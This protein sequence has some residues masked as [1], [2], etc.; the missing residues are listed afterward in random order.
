MSVLAA[1][2]F[3]RF[4]S[5]TYLV[6]LA[7]LPLIV[8]LSLRSLSGL[9]PVRRWLA[10][11]LR[12]LV[13]TTMVFALA[14]AQR[15]Q[16]TD[17]LS[18]I[19][20][21]DRS[22]S[23]PRDQQ[24]SAFQFVTSSKEGLRATKDR[25][26]VV[27]FDGD[28]AVE[29]LPMGGLGITKIGDPVRPENTNIEEALAMAMALFTD[30]TA[31]RVVLLSDGNENV[32]HAL[33]QAD[34]Y[35]AAGVPIDVLPIRYEHGDE[36]VFER[37]SAPPTATSEETVDLQMV[38]RATKET[39]GRVTLFHNDK[40]E[41]SQPV[42]LDAGANRLKMSVPMR[43]AGAHRFRAVFDPET[44]AQ[45]SISANNEGRAFTV[46]SGQGKILILTQGGEGFEDDQHS[47]EIL[48]RALESE[49]LMC[50]V[51]VVGSKPIDQVRLL[52]FSLVILSN[53]PANT[54]PEDAR[55]TL[56][57][58]VRDLGGGLI[59][60]GGD[61]SFGAGGW[62]DTPIE[63][64]MPVTFD[65][66]SKKQ[67]PKGAL[68][69]VMHACE[70]PQG[71]YWGERVAIA[72][73]KTLSSRDLIGVL[74]YQWKDADQK[75]WDVPLQE[76]RDKAKIVQ[77]IKNMQMGDMPDL[78]A[79]MRPG[80]EELIK[81][82][83]A[84]A[85]HM[86]V[87]SDFDPAPPRS[88]LLAT[89]KK[90]N[91]TC[92]TVA[93]GWGGHNID[94]GKA[95][96]I[97]DETGGKY[98]S[99]QDY[100]ELPQIFIKESR[101]VRRTLVQEVQFTPQLVNIP[102]SLIEGLRGEGVPDLGGYVLCTPK[103]A[104]QI[105]M[106]RLTEEG[107]DPIL[108]NWQVGL[109]KTVAFT[110]GL[111]PRWGADWAAW[112]KFSKLWAQIARW[113]ARQSAASSFDVSTSVTGGKG[114]IRIDAL[115][116]DAGAMNFMNIEGVLVDPRSDAKPLQMTQTGPGR[117]EAEF[118]AQSPGSYVVSLAYRTGVG[119]DRVTGTLQT[120]VSVAYS[121]EYRELRT[122]DAMLR[123]LS[124][125]TGG[126]Q[127]AP[128]EAA[129]AFET[130]SLPRAEARRSIWEDLVRWMLLLFLLDVAVRRIAI[131]PMEM[132]RKLRVFINEMAGR[133]TPEA[134]AATLSTL[135][136]SRDKA[137]EG[138]GA[139]A[140]SA[141]EA[142]PAP[143]RSARYEAPVP[144]AK[145]TEQ[146]SQALG[147]A[148]EVDQPVVAKPTRKPTPTSEAD[149]TSRLLKAKKQ[150]RDKM[151]ESEEQPPTQ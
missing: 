129:S 131:N 25:M 52:E 62:M 49:R 97:A 16:T 107:Q 42:T 7:V 58:Y 151:D 26:G 11:G 140:P 95:Q 31:R 92:S 37:L 43:V 66:K 109:G 74:S 106:V 54:V 6:L 116:K 87:I 130:G 133:R 2:P 145:V 137:R 24:A 119:S 104:A 134:A 132:L 47:A 48:A 105:P 91:I 9:G 50:E 36:V 96:K 3:I 99:T 90:N 85:R 141:S 93:I 40:P 115:D 110:S 117:Y 139:A 118:E 84:A 56:A 146:L 65:I 72:A 83:D 136:G 39:R 94:T 23:I 46:V 103:A 35:K 82:R 144:D 89:M 138:M 67:I 28:S 88:D 86:I 45:D 34:Q 68:A 55:K 123:E 30:D 120:G 5:P 113:S 1:A 122:N 22:A 102:S 100:R 70:I 111:W 147:G 57:S 80:V 71:N 12:C 19:F 135:K 33:D 143:N 13:V 76:V 108:A 69:L 14:G 8:A 4:E 79:V 51:E 125:R 101:V 126:R 44:T 81:R 53:I 142:G 38:L 98:Y 149:F 18:V 128:K 78:D 32:G 73:V 77:L 150:V 60:V 41:Q 127:L 121:P 64:V 112:P 10:I 21:V 29:Q 15:T 27:A 63:E 148:S 61:E 59:M 124:E 17:S 75:Y 20:L 114:R